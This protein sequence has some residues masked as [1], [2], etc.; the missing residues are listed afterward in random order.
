[1]GAT[2]QYEDISDNRKQFSPLRHSISGSVGNLMAQSAS[3]SI[4][5][6]I[7]TVCSNSG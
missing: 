3:D 1:M 7:K 5:T 4:L 2:I 6:P